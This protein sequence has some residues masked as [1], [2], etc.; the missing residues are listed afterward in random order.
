LIELRLVNKY[1]GGEQ[2]FANL[3]IQ[4]DTGERVAIVGPSGCGKTT[5]LNI[6]AGLDSV[7]SGQVKIDGAIVSQPEQSIASH[8]RGIGFMF[9]RP[10]LWPHMTVMQN[11]GFGVHGK[12][13]TEKHKHVHQLLEKM[14]I[15]N[16]ANRFPDQLSGGQQQRVALARALAPEPKRLLLDEPFNHLDSSLKVQLTDLVKNVLD[17]INATLLYVTHDVNEVDCLVDRVLYLEAEKS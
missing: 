12:N 14:D 10:A 17:D 4:V 2:V 3:S 8:K 1:F 9:Q 16:L 7:D 5:L 11:V 13:Q 15:H 6:I